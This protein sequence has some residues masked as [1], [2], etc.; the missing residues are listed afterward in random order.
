MTESHS[1]NGSSM[2]RREC[3]ATGSLAAGSLLLPATVASAQSSSGPKPLKVALIGCGNRGTGAAAQM[4]SAG[5]NVILWAMA[6]AFADRIESSLRAL[7][8]GRAGRYGVSQGKGFGDAVDVPE[9]RQ[10]VGLDAFQKVMEMDEIDLVILTTP[11]GFRPQQF[12]A[13]VEADKHVFMEKPLATDAVGVRRMLATSE[14][15]KKKNLKVGVGLQRHHQPSYQEAIKRIQDGQIGQV[16]AL[17]CFWNSGPP[18]KTAIFPDDSMTELEYQVRNWYF[19][20]WLSGDHICEQHIHNIDVCNWVKGDHPVTAEGMGGRQ[21]RTGK[22]EGNIFDHHAVIFTYAD[23]TKMY[24]YCRQ[25]PGCSRSV[26]EFVDGSNGRAELGTSECALFDG[27]KEL[28]K[29][30]RRNA[31]RESPYQVE[32]DVLVDAIR[33][34]KEHN[35][36]EYGAMSTMTAILGRLATYSGKEISWE[37]A[38]NA[39]DSITTDALSWDA[40]APVKPLEEGG[41][42]IAVPGRT[43]VV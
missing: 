16:V 34:D 39:K 21:V 25:I 3:L 28:W 35:E 18:A 14:K 38:Y 23:G 12:E 9:S 33:N 2:N 24:S 15:A 6:D 40:E 27:E 31:D 22:N 10:F 36:V 41:Y 8:R 4:L 7:S 29:S 43:E 1:Q 17:R 30:N 5:E 32:L 37:E 20:D 42:R 13:A 26:A 19:F 11:P